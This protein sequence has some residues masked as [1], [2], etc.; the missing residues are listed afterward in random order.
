MKIK[1]A[2]LVLTGKLEA[3]SKEML[4][5]VDRG[6]KVIEEDKRLEYLA[7]YKAEK[8]EMKAKFKPGV[9]V[10]ANQSAGFNRGACGTVE[11]LEPNHLRVWVLRDGAESACFYFPKELD[12]I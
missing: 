10:Q 2:W 3:V 7:K 6:I 8:E 4:A 12:L 9:R 1:Q 11:Y 5:V